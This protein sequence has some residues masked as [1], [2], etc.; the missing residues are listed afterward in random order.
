[1]NSGLTPQGFTI[2][3][4]LIVLSLASFMF[5]SA[6]FSMN[7]D[8][9]Q[10]EF[11]TGARQIYT[12]LQSLST[13]VQN[14][15]YSNN[16]VSCT[17]DFNYSSP[18]PGSYPSF[19]NTP[20]TPG[21]N[22]GCVY[23]GKAIQFNP[24]SMASSHYNVYSIVGVQYIDNK[25]DL[26]P[27]F[28]A[29]ATVLSTVRGSLYGSAPTGT[30]SIN[31]PDQFTVSKITYANNPIGAGN[32]I[33]GFYN[34]QTNNT[35]ASSSLSDQ[36]FILPT[37]GL[38]ISEAITSLNSDSVSMG[39]ESIG[40]YDLSPSKPITVCFK[41]PLESKQAVNISFENQSSS[42]N[43]VLSYSYNGC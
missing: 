18:L 38:T 36:L 4:V 2:I 30:Q 23:L 24:G 20:L 27:G 25:L 34:T 37:S 33:L 3:E 31:L 41:S 22:L 16:N 29:Y 17:Y 1:M 9:K 6:A 8:Q 5:V 40:E 15:L 14:G 19:P 35:L 39:G 12:Q 21:A 28:P 43:L 7:S 32:D 13:D 42:A 26:P 11:D 10:T